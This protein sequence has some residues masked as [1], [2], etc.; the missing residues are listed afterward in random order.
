MS[1]LC[2]LG[3]YHEVLGRRWFISGSAGNLIVF[4]EEDE[5]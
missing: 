2:E 4:N 3:Y 1:N 5:A